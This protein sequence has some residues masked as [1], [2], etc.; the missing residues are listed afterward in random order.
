MKSNPEMDIDLGLAVLEALLPSGV[1]L[2]QG[3]IAEVCGCS[4]SMIYLIELNALK[5][6]R[7]HLMREK[8]ATEREALH[9]MLELCAR[10]AA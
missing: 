3:D 10:R 5:K 9:E 7:V 8:N 6:I 1:S 4:R 2:T